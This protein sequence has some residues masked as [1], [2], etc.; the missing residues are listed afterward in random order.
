MSAKQALAD[1]LAS[2]L[3]RKIPAPTLVASALAAM[4][5]PLMAAVGF[6]VAAA[7]TALGRIGFEV[8]SALLPTLVE[9]ARKGVQ[10]LGDWLEKEI[11]DKPEVNEAA[12]HTM[13]EQAETVAQTLQ[14]ARPDDRS[15]IADAVG[16]GLKEYRG[17]TAVIADQYAAA[18]KNP[19][20]LSKLV[21]EMR[22]ALGA[23]GSQ[24]IE[25]RDGSKI[26]NVEMQMKSGAGEQV[27]RADKNSS[28][29]DV[30]QHMG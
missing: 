27:V 30:K 3:I 29:S 10:A 14:E 16:Q 17:A 9:V 15:E 11:A 4:I 13:V 25:A 6:D 18:M 5:H 24:T 26:K 1:L 19:A 22:A 8:G 21:E 7:T 2:P 28:I 12:A 20:E 23:W